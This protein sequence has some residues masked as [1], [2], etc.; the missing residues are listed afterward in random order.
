MQKDFA[1]VKNS[2]TE[3]ST[4]LATHTESLNE[5]RQASAKLSSQIVESPE[6]LK[7]NL[8]DLE[9]GVTTEN[10][11]VQA[12]EKNSRDLQLK[13][14]SFTQVEAVCVSPPSL[15]SSP[16][17][18]SNFLFLFVCFQDLD[19]SMALMEEAEV[20]LKKL[21]DAQQRVTAAQDSLSKKTIEHKDLCLKE[22]VSF[23]SLSF[24]FFY[25]VSHFFISRC[26]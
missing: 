4:K 24:F 13:I 16:P 14:D 18:H 17:L 5:L 20:E 19:K 9:T 2:A 25:P 11:A 8:L 26:G 3:L 23:L 15:S 6:K 21:Q 12:L 10:E 7:Q 22:Q 1:A